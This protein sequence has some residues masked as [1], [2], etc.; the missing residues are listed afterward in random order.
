[1]VQHKA[2]DRLARKLVFVIG[3]QSK[4]G[5]AATAGGAFLGLT[6][7]TQAAFA[8]GKSNNMHKVAS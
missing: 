3:Q 1:M 4:N 2:I 5:W 8:G 7:A 6:L